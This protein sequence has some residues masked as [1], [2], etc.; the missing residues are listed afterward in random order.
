L[1][2]YELIKN[3]F[4]YCFEDPAYSEGD[5]I[6]M[7]I[8]NDNRS[9]E[10]YNQTLAIYPGRGCYYNQTLPT[11]ISFISELNASYFTYVKSETT[12]ICDFNNTYEMITLYSN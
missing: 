1:W 2:T 8:I 9:S 7:F 4:V 10:K 11:K 3:Y 6:T 12:G 5:D